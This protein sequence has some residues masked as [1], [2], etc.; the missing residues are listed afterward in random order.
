MSA[1]NLIGQRITIEVKETPCRCV[2]PGCSP[3]TE[4][5]TGK[6]RGWKWMPGGHV[7]DFKCF[8]GDRADVTEDDIKKEIHS[9][10][11]QRKM[12]RATVSHDPPTTGVVAQNVRE[13]IKTL[14]T[15][16]TEMCPAGRCSEIPEIEVTPEMIAAGEAELAGFDPN[17][18]NYS[19]CVT[20]I[21][22][23]MARAR[24]RGL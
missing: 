14:R 5:T 16:K 22:L 11:M 3:L 17:E 6:I 10:V 23:V 8:R 13:F 20:A 12:K 18:D 15:M 19:E 4:T 7:V 24:S 9:A 21:Y 1:K 2:F